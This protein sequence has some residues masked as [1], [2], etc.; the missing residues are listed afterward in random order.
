MLLPNLEA[1]LVFFKILG[2]PSA[3]AAIYA[4]IPR[5]SVKSYNLYPVYLL[6]FLSAIRS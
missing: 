1:F 6:A 3:I 4:I 5:S 2:N